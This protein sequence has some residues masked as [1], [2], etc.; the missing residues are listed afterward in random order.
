MTKIALGRYVTCE[1]TE[2]TI[3]GRVVCMGRSL[4]IVRT[5]DDDT[6]YAVPISELELPANAAPE[7]SRPKDQPNE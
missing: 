5:V 6:E 3:S 7:P 4:A 2:G 1:T